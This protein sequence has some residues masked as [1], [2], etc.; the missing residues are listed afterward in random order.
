MHIADTFTLTL[1]FTDNVPTR[2]EVLKSIGYGFPNSP[3]PWAYY[4]RR[5]D[6]DSGAGVAWVTP[7]DYVVPV[8]QLHHPKAY[9]LRLFRQGCEMYGSEVVYGGTAIDLGYEEQFW[10]ILPAGPSAVLVMTKGAL[11]NERHDRPSYWSVVH[12]RT[13]QLSTT[14]IPWEQ[15]AWERVSRPWFI[16]PVKTPSCSGIKWS[17]P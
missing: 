13:G 2:F 15:G 12:L 14:R 3:D 9:S 17:W 10:P 6:T 1:F 16:S 8:A 4:E 7:I 11:R 5:A